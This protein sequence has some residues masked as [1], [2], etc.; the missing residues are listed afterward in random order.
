MCA[1]LFLIDSQ[2]FRNFE[3]QLYPGACLGT[4]RYII[5]MAK[6]CGM[7]LTHSKID[8]SVAK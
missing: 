7:T 8:K 5:D 4:F 3:I 6:L 1:D 2:T